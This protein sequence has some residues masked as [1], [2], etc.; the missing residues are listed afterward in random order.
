MPGANISSVLSISKASPKH[1][2]QMGPSDGVH[3]IDVVFNQACLRTLPP[4]FNKA[5]SIPNNYT[6]R[7]QP[8][9]NKRLDRA[10]SNI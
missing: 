5:N 4:K 3:I 2:K 1:H 6:N 9:G 8:S 10:Y 7:Y